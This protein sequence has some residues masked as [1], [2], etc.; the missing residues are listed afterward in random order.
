MATQLTRQERVELID[1]SCAEHDLQKQT[2]LL[3]LNRSGLY[4]VPV[5]VSSTELA[6]K[7]KIDEL[8]TAYPFYGSRKIAAVLGINRKAAQRHMREMGIEAI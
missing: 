7:N 4:Y 6:L 2:E 8:H 5:A 1:W 3:S